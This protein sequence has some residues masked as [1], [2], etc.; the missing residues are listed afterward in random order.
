MQTLLALTDFSAT[1]QS[2]IQ[3]A[4]RLARQLRARLILLHA[5]PRHSQWL[6]DLNDELVREARQKL[7]KTKDQLTGQG[8][9]AEAIATDVINQ[10]PLDKVARDY[11]QAS[12]ASLVVMGTEGASGQGNSALGSFVL[13][14]MENSPVPVIA[15]PGDGPLRDISQIVYAT[16]LQEVFV[17]M[18]ILAPYARAFRA[19]VDLLHVVLP[20]AEPVPAATELLTQLREQ[21]AYDHISITVRPGNDVEAAVHQF[22]REQGASRSAP[23]SRVNW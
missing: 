21:N 6:G 2:A 7:Q 13:D 3:Y 15:V 12:H 5:I 20:G 11:A 16:D 8:L 1:A 18:S 22:T 4:A 10:F 23:C 14:V 17:E 9:P 19:S